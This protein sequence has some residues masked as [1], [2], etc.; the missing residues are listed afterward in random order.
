M[1][2]ERN[3]A[4]CGCYTFD[5]LATMVVRLLLI[6]LLSAAPAFSQEAVKNR[7]PLAPNVFNTLPLTAVKPQ[8]WLKRQL[9]IQ[10][11][12][13]TGHLDEFWPSLALDSGWLGGQGESWERGPYFLDGLVPLAWLLDSVELK[14]KAQRWVNW[15][16]ENQRPDGN[17][18]PVKNTDW[19][20]IFV[21]LKVLAQYQEATGDARVVPLMQ[22]YFAYMSQH[23]DER[24][25]KEWAIYRWGDQIY[26]IAWLYNRTGDASLLELAKKLSR[27]GYDWKAHFAD[28]QYPGKVTPQQANLKTHV[29]N[30]AMAMKTSGVWSWFSRDK[31]DREAIYQLLKVMDQHHLMPGGVH[32]GD[33]HYAGRSPVQGTELCAV[34][35]GMYSL[36]LMTGVTGDA[37]FGDRLERMAFNALPGTFDT[38]MWAH[39]YDQQPN[40]VMVDIQRRDW[41]TNGPEANLYGLE[42]N[43]GCCTANFHQGWPK[44]AANLWM[45][46]A[47]DGLAA[48]AYGPSEVTATVRGGV[49]V[50]ITE[51]TEY[52]FRETVRLTVAPAKAAEFALVLRVPAWATKAAIEVNGKAEPGVKAGTFHRISRRWSAG[53]KITLRFPME[54]RVTRWYNQTAAVERGPLVF[55]LRIGQEWKKLRDRGPTADWAV[56]A[57]SPW[58]YALVLEGI[59]AAEAPVGEY[60]FGA[61]SPPVVLKAKG[62]KL[63]G[64]QIQNGSAAPPPQSPVATSEPLETIELIPYGAAKLRI[65]EFPVAGK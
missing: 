38:Q 52:P 36:E 11:Q 5:T 50:K 46:T 59:E 44:F 23:I 10:A 42:P 6:A 12:G 3:S 54:V 41:T 53:D 20:P 47:D 64:W 24:P 34:V 62:R 27:Q 21:Q 7:A 39:Q 19:W 25:L 49:K 18:G 65:T 55:S 35:E 13:Q 14:G 61:D 63:P 4:R 15:T 58:N 2:V 26:T 17:I 9:Q 31:A 30:N 16:L 60:P 32:G 40:Q 1:T 8:G 33:E 22:K 56:Y 43:F 48:I 57:T 28:F 37:A 29:V 51:E 45:G